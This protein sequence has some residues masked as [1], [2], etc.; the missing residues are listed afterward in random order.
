[1]QIEVQQ[2]TLTPVTFPPATPA[3]S[4]FQLLLPLLSSSPLPWSS[5][6]R[7]FN[8]HTKSVHAKQPKRARA[9]WRHEP[10]P[11]EPFHKPHFSPTL[12]KTATAAGTSQFQQ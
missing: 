7:P 10:L 8:A 11:S 2:S 3:L 12:P 4:R 5:F 9:L 6:S 1:M